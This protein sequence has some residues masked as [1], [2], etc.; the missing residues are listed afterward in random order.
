MDGRKIFVVWFFIFIILLINK[1]IE[2]NKAKRG[3]K[4]NMGEGNTK[5]C[6]EF[7]FFS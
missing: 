7:K 4:M 3:Y 1:D 5:F 6:K 2:L